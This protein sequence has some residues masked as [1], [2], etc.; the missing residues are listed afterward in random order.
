MRPENVRAIRLGHGANC[1][2]IGSVID[3][4]FVA[5][6]VSGAIFAVV[7]AAMKEEDVKVVGDDEPEDD[8]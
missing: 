3:T 7:L 2:S 5:A 8:A 4:L 6:V 1:S